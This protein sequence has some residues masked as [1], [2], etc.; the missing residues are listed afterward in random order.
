[1]L[2]KNG[3]YF[4]L[5]AYL[6]AAS[7]TIFHFNGTGDSGDSPM[8]YLFA[9]YAPQHPELYFNHWAKPLFVLLASPFAQFGFV[10]LKVFNVLAVALTTLLTYRCAEL[11]SIKNKLVVA[12]ILLFTPLYFVLTFSA[13]TEPLFALFI[14][15]G[16]Y[17]VLKHRLTAGAIV[18]SLL[19]FIRSEG[20]IILGVFAFYFIVKKQWKV[21]PY[22]AF[23][24]MFYAVAGFAVYK[25]LLWIFKKIPYAQLSS[26]YGQGE[27]T[28]FVEQLYY[29][30]GLPI[31]I[32][33]WIG[34]LV[35]VYKSI[36]K[37]I[38]SEIFI[39]VFLGF[40]AFFTAHT[41]FWYL[42]IFNSM[43]LK[44][45]L[46]GVMPLLSIIAMI[47]FNFLTEEVF[48]F[49]ASVKKLLQIALVIVILIFP[50]TQ[51]H[52]AIHWETDLS[53]TQDQ[54]MAHK[55]ANFVDEELSDEHRFIFA[56]PYLN[57]ALGIDPFDESQKLE[58]Q[59]DVFDKLK[60][61]NIIIWD[62]WF[63]VLERGVTSESMAEHPQ[64]KEVF[65]CEKEGQTS[66]IVYQWK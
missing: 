26:I 33:F 27:L 4:I 47:G 1:M 41:L 55:I 30:V 9:K 64:F 6:I 28:H 31:Y 54:E 17:A 23:G 38:S 50:F 60:Q 29:T 43:G 66:L 57:M 32:L 46:I 53:L 24:H 59:L 62:S 8:H 63:S 58:L 16:L 34:S 5:F 2:R 7:F 65:R 14:A 56:H 61:G 37:K 36:R 51:N 21:L 49:N 25:D 10:G 48:S 45:V 13:L 44:R 52:A 3:I 39:L 19:P 18:V 12:L 11:L 35:L 22:L 40:F 15:A 20:L 42:G